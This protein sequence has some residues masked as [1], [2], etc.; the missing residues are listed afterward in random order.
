MAA[1]EAFSTTSG[2]C[3]PGRFVAWL[4][5]C[6]LAAV[7]L[8][9]IAVRIE[10]ARAP[11]IVFPL[12][13][14]GAVGAVAAGVARCA[15]L[16]PGRAALG[17]VLLCAAVTVAGQHTFAWRQWLG[18]LEQVSQ[19]ARTMG[20]S[21]GGSLTV[22]L[23]PVAT[24]AM[25]LVDYLRNEAAQGRP[26]IAGRWQGVWAWATWAADALLLLAAAGAVFAMT[27]RKSPARPDAISQ[28][29]S[30]EP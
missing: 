26:W 23:G 1:A 7:A 19:R 8:A 25:G 16:P 20:A 28:A 11:V 24:P 3:E 6:L 13:V 21:H 9:W 22:P 5:I 15:G 17:G 2:R 29:P 27:Q 18:L 14:G 12:V 4:A 10:T 30:P